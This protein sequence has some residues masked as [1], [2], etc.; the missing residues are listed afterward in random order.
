[1]GQLAVPRPITDSTT[2]TKSSPFRFLDLPKEVQSKIIEIT[3]IMERQDFR[4]NQ[5]LEDPLDASSP[6]IYDFNINAF[7]MRS[8][9]LPPFGLLFVNREVSGDALAV[10]YQNSSFAVYAEISRDGV[11]DEA[12]G[13]IPKMVKHISPMVKE[14]AREVIFRISTINEGPK[15][16][17][18]SPATINQGS[19]LRR[20]L[21]DLGVLLS[22][23]TFP[24]VKALNV[25]SLS[26]SEYGYSHRNIRKLLK[27][28]I[29]GTAWKKHA[30][31]HFLRNR[32]L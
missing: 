11:P 5:P 20:A 24:Y 22:E 21:S 4:P 28:S 18:D 1:L 27:H 3:L 26:Y 31:S 29:L 8:H 7:G 19:A 10:V 2:S 13:C 17:P 9:T 32:C 25:V 6:K 16:L 30:D 14:N 23:A 15:R 12:F